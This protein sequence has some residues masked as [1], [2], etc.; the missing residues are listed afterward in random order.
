MVIGENGRDPSGDPIL[1][2]FA[3]ILKRHMP[4]LEAEF[5]VSSLGLFGSYVRGEQERGSDLDVLV[6]FREAP[7]LFGFMDLEERLSDLLGVE[8]ELVSRGS[9]KGNIGRNILREVV[10]V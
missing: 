1:D 5:K 10:L 2:R 9:L 8:V 6:E 4:E 7:D 3:A